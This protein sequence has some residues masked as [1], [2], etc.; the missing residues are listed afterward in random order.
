MGKAEYLT[1]SSQRCKER[2]VFIGFLCGLC[3]NNTAYLQ[4]KFSGSLNSGSTLCFQ[5]LLRSWMLKQTCFDVE[6]IHQP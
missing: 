2:K 5:R 1:H 4:H 6:N 3:V